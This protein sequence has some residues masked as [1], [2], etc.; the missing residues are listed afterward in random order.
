MYSDVITKNREV[1]IKDKVYIIEEIEFTRESLRTSGKYFTETKRETSMFFEASDNLEDGVFIYQDRNNPNIGYRIYK[2]FANPGFYSY[3]E[4]KLIAKLSEKQSVI[5]R[6][7]FPTSILTLEGRVIGQKIPLYLNHD[8]IHKHVINSKELPTEYYRQILDILKEMYDNGIGYLDGHSKNFIIER[9]S[10][11]VELI[12]FEWSKMEFDSISSSSNWKIFNNLNS[13]I[14]RCNENSKTDDILSKSN[15]Q[16]FSEAYEYV[17]E[18][19]YKLLKS[20][21]Y[22]K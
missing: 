12:D 15:V 7:K 10:G 18:S 21:R 14:N 16:T 17:E 9:N 1:K 4:D 8:E 5:T 19:E 13:L 22:C 3:S 11:H 2:E 6:T 20:K